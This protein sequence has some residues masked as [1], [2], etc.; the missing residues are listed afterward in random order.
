VAIPVAGIGARTLVAR[1]TDLNNI[2]QDE[3]YPITFTLDA[4]PPFITLDTSDLTTADTWQLG[5]GILRFNGTASD[6]VGLA[7]VQVKVDD[8]P[9]ANATFGNGVWRTALLV[10][11]P[12]GRPVEVTAR[13]I[14]FAGQVTLVSHSLVTNLSAAD[15]PDTTITGGP[16]NP[17]DDNTATFTFEGIPGGR[18]A[19]AFECMLDKG[20]FT[21]CTSPWSYSDLSKG[22]HTFAVRAIDSE[23]YVDLSPASFTWTINAT[24]L[25]AMIT[26]A[27]SNPSSSRDATFGFTGNGSGF[28][29]A[30]DGADFAPCTTPHH[31]SGLAYGLHSF[32][33][34]ALDNEGN[35]GAADRFL[36]IVA[37]AAPVAHDQALTTVE[38]KPVA[39]TLAASDSD[40][41]TYKVGTPAHG[42]LH[43]IPPALTYVPN[44]GFSGIDSFTFV[45]KDGLVDSNIATI[46]IKINESGTPQAVTLLDFDVVVVDATTLRIVWSTASELNVIGFYV[47]RSENGDRSQGVLVTPD[48]IEPQGDLLFGAEYEVIDGSLRPDTQYSYWLQEIDWNGKVSE[49]GP[50][51]VRTPGLPVDTPEDP[52]EPEDPGT[53][54]GVDRPG[55]LDRIYLPLI[56][57]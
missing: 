23:G 18:E 16:S 38:E 28:E 33:V 55:G 25:D 40:P 35:R 30:L 37:N 14:D 47:W 45:A 36:W 50:V 26:S 42:A 31:Y 34:R 27:P 52:G 22:S 53:P 6:D 48:L 9:F 29:C 17:S 1:A 12:Q 13:A 8:Q 4:Q 20:N 19:T 49:F 7:A 21:P 54:A 32:Q 57:R 56:N 15:A 2:L 41:L 24:A 51:T 46:S 5:S 10:N 44:S 3:L 39:I 11:D 43:G